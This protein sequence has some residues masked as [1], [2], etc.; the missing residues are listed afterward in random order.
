MIRILT[1]K[2]AILLDANLVIET[3]MV[4]H[5]PWSLFWL[6]NTTIKYGLPLLC[7]WHLIIS[8]ALVDFNENKN[9]TYIV[10]IWM[11]VIVKGRNHVHECIGAIMKLIHDLTLEIWYLYVNESHQYSAH[12]TWW[13][14]CHPTGWSLGQRSHTG[15]RTG[16]WSTPTIQHHW[17]YNSLKYRFFWKWSS[18][19]VQFSCLSLK[20]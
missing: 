1:C 5:F 9:Q 20:E 10:S 13:Y 16:T 19:I 8:H 17:K 18:L 12:D 6:R 14:Q 15:T 7:S 3:I 2:N 11:A 4:M